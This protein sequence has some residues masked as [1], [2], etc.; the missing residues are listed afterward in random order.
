FQRVLTA[1]NPVIGFLHRHPQVWMSACN[2]S[3]FTRWVLH[4][5]LLQVNKISSNKSRGSYVHIH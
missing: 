4:V 5:S 2:F 1:S 3:S